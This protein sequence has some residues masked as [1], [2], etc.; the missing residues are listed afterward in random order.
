MRYFFAQAVF[1]LATSSLTGTGCS[2]GPA[3]KLMANKVT[4]E[5][6]SVT[7]NGGGD[8]GLTPVPTTVR[9]P[10]GN[11]RLAR[12]EADAC[13]RKYTHNQCNVHLHMAAYWNFT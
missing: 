6:M 9:H 1:L 5:Y 11:D 10:Q 8:P 3:A 2:G 7:N 13:A 12:I 4:L